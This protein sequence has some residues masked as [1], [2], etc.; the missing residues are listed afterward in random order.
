ME[1]WVPDSRCSALWLEHPI[2]NGGDMSRRYR[3]TPRKCSSTFDREAEDVVVAAH[4]YGAIVGGGAVKGLEKTDA[5]DTKS[6][7]WC[8]VFSLWR[9]GYL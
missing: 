6:R 5:W 9:V 8:R 1:R 4:S 7:R 2:S 3:F